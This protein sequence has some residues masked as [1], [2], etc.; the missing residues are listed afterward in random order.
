[1]KEHALARAAKAWRYQGVLVRDLAHD[2]VN[3]FPGKDAPQI[4][5][6]GCRRI[7][8]SARIGRLEDRWRRFRLQQN[9]ER[10]CNKV[11]HCIVHLVHEVVVAGTIQ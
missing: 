10:Q 4:I 9:N 8:L 1:M 2:S 11:C 5:T 7:C 6:D 3:D